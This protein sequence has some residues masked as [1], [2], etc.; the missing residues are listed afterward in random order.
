MKQGELKI[1]EQESPQRRDPGGDEDVSLLSV[2][3]EH[4][5]QLVLTGLIATFLAY[6]TLN[7]VTPT[8]ASNSQVLLEA[9]AAPVIDI[10]NAVAEAPDGIATLESAII[11]MRSPQVM[12]EVVRELNLTERAEF[13]T[14]LRSPTL[15]DR[16]LGAPSALVGQLKTLFG[17]T[18]PERTEP[19]DPV[20]KSAIQLREQ[21]SVRSIGESRVIEVTAESESSE[22]AAAIANA[23]ARAY[24]DQEVAVKNAAGERA[25]IWLEERANKL[26]EQ[27]EDNESRLSDYRRD[28]I[29]SGRAVSTDLDA[30][31]A[32]MTTTM[33]QLTAER[34]ELEAQRDEISQ[35]REAGNFLTLASAA[36]LPTIA[37][38]T[39]QLSALEG[40]IIEL[41]SIYGDHPRTRVA[42]QTR[43]QL[44]TLLEA[45]TA[46]LISGLEI[47]I[48]VLDN[49]LS[50]LMTNMRET[51]SA[52]V[53]TREDDL[54][55]AA[56]TREV[57]VSRSIYERFLLRQ[58]EV[59]E[60]SLFQTPGAR[61]VSEAERP[62]FP[63]A[64]QK[65]KLALLSGIGASGMMLFWL[66]FRPV[67]ERD[68]PETTEGQLDL[69]QLNRIGTLFEVPNIDTIDKP[70]DI[71]RYLRA[72]PDS[73]LGIALGWLQNA[74]PPKYDDWTNLIFITSAERG[75]GKSTLSLLLAETF[76]REYSTL[77]INADRA[78]WLSEFAHSAEVEGA[79]FTM[80]ESSV[81]LLD[82][83]EN[84][85]AVE[86]N[87]SD[88]PGTVLGANVIIVNAPAMP[89]SPR[90]LAIGQLADHTVFACALNKS[91][92]GY[93]HR[94]VRA[95][96]DLG[97]HA[98][99]LALNMMARNKPRALKRFPRAISALRLPMRPKS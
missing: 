6:S 53:G 71:L 31:L 83:L 88:R 13:N 11:L 76:S 15:I 44:L 43:R 59:S 89:M 20:V 61:L 90:V 34:T 7:Q 5:R 40:S 32:D 95:L 97:I 74:V 73:D 94:C 54:Q 18:S 41:E 49:R 45:E 63:I 80:L 70:A 17:A 56:L 52:L 3:L 87:L 2:A 79:G 8:Y 84:E 81:D 96:N 42:Q 99:V 38:L 9:L 60:R 65:S 66:A 75:V 50:D 86:S 12:Q 62:S 14:A 72:H 78:G 57:E 68:A 10:P 48:G 26:R 1:S 93:I 22:L 25:A 29:A 30:Q 47:R 58:K 98:S 64:P 39:Q 69:V 23:V 92:L 55:F 35:L 36:E 51:R 46:R 24:I 85:F 19:R 28:L 37:A 33:V 21:V 27:L 77:L 4:K 67:R 16:I 91:H 82:R